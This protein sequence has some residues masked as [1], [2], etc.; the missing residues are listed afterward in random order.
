MITTAP[1]PLSGA[2]KALDEASASVT[3]WV[4]SGV[5]SVPPAMS[6]H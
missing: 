3:I 6:T 1:I 5:E 4:G 2:A